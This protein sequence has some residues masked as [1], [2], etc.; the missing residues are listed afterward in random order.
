MVEFCD[1][2][3]ENIRYIDGTKHV[4]K[5]GTCL[6]SILG[7]E[8]SSRRPFPFKTRVMRVPEIYKTGIPT[9]VCGFNPFE[10]Y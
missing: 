4:Y 3:T 10:K 2:R 1:Q 6:S 9:L 5:P 7:F 8:P